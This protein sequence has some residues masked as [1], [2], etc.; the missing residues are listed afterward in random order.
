MRKVNR[1]RKWLVLLLT[2]ITVGLEFL[3]SL[4]ANI[5]SSLLQNNPGRLGPLVRHPF[6]TGAG[7]IVVIAIVGVIMWRYLE[8]ESATAEI[9]IPKEVE[10]AAEALAVK[11]RNQA[12]DW[13]ALHMID[14]P[15]PLPVQWTNAPDRLAAPWSA[16]R[17]NWDNTSQIALD[18]SIEQIAEIFAKVPSSR[19][20]VLGGRGSGKT[21]I[22]SRFMLSLLPK[23]GTVPVGV[24]LPVL[25]SMASWDPDQ[26]KLRTWLTEEL[27]GVDPTLDRLMPSGNKLAYELLYRGRIL[28]ILDGLD[29]MA[30]SVRAAALK[31]LSDSLQ[32]DDR[33]LVTSRLAEYSAAVQQVGPLAEAAA[34]VI[35]DLQVTDLTEYFGAIPMARQ[36]DSWSFVLA[37]LADAATDSSAAA[38]RE[39]FKTPLMVFMARTVYQAPT[40]DPKDLLTIGDANAIRAQ[41]FQQFVPSAYD[42]G[43]GTRATRRSHNRVIKA[44]RYLRTL[45]THLA[46]TGVINFRWWQLHQGLSRRDQVFLGVI[47]GVA[48]T[49]LLALL[50]RPFGVETSILDGPS[51]GIL[52]GCL[53]GFA[54]RRPTLLGRKSSPVPVRVR[55]W[56]SARTVAASPT[57]RIPARG[58]TR[59]FAW[60]FGLLVGATNGIIW[61]ITAIAGTFETAAW[62]FINVTVSTA[63]PIALA[64]W[65]AA[66]LVQTVEEPVNLAQALGPLDLLR[67]DR[68]TAALEAWVY[69]LVA[70]IIGAIVTPM[71]GL[72]LSQAAH[73]EQLLHMGNLDLTAIDITN[74]VGIPLIETPVVVVFVLLF[75]FTAWGRFT[76]ARLYFAMTRQLPWHL[77]TFLDDAHRRGILRQAG[78]VYQFRHVEIRNSLVSKSNQAKKG[79]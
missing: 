12:L 1:K 21:V 32:R 58:S 41:L 31:A 74:I 27:V 71:L 26:K 40:A 3:N 42:E 52:L 70:A 54:I 18:G 13:E 44:E 49:G 22:A 62:E 63:I 24:T 23:A 38:L 59:G 69:G 65:L 37:R 64:T 79:T 4:A 2:L 11:L 53:A 48:V 78:A 8:E 28:P 14:R 19:L 16:I 50:V 77:M 9:D 45:A 29:E 76:L 35:D 73:P 67:L 68:S 43:P 20:V 66:R 33:V 56:H 34:I 10:R 5:G 57:P 17:R 61:A 55:G 46:D 7:L 15:A 75:L 60:R 25:F 39:V 6:L 51:L 47:V 72:V 30:S 36:R